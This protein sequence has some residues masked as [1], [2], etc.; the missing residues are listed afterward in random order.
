MIGT[1][2]SLEGFTGFRAGLDVRGNSTGTHSVHTNHRDYQIMFHVSTML[3][4]SAVNKQQVDRKRHIGNDVITIIFQEPGAGQFSPAL[5]GVRSQFQHI[6]IIVRAHIHKSTQQ[7]I[8]FNVS[9]N[10]YRFYS[11]SDTQCRLPERNVFL[12]LD[13]NCQKVLCSLPTTY[14]GTSF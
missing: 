6:F 5:S 3:P 13:Q 12:R 11:R 14:S 7:V 1:K 10:I 2:I 8:R 9:K 4:Y